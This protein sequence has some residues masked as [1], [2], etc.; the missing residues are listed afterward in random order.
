MPRTCNFACFDGP[1]FLTFK[2]CTPRAV[3]KLHNTSVV[4]LAPMRNSFKILD[5]LFFKQVTGI[6]LILVCHYYAGYSNLKNNVELV[7]SL[8]T[9]DHLVLLKP[10][11]L[12][13]VGTNQGFSFG[14]GQNIQWFRWT[15]AISWQCVPVQLIQFVLFFW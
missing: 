3:W 11:Q 4:L 8:E 6:A 2:L 1:T 14:R 7:V 10:L 12:L 9:R 13:A 5:R 15:L